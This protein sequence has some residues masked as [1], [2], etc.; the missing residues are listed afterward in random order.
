MNKDQTI[1][2]RRRR[3]Y[4]SEFKS[5]AVALV[6]KGRTISDVASSL[7]ISQSLL[8]KWHGASRSKE[9]GVAGIDLEKEEMRRY[10]KQLETERDILKKA[11]TIFSRT[12]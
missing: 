2:Y 1:N 7:G 3:H 4:D 5:S 11:L 8:R 10:I 12:P 9:V 6:S